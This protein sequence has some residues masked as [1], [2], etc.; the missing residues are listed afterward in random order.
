MTG[1]QIR[2]H[3]SEIIDSLVLDNNP[4]VVDDDQPD[5]LND[6]EKRNGAIDQLIKIIENYREDL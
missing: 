1:S 5:L 2:T 6:S 3:L 4:T